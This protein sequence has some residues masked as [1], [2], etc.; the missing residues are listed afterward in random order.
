MSVRI[1]KINSSARYADASTRRLTEAVVADLL[2]R[3]PD[4]EVIDRD[5]AQG[6]PFVS[7]GHIEAVYTPT[8][9]RTPAQRQLLS[10]S[11]HLISELK[12][13]DYLVIGAPMY[14]FSV[15]ASLKAY[16]DQIAQAGVTFSYSEAGPKGLVDNIREAFVAVS[17]N[18][19]PL[20][21]PVDFLTGFVRHYLGFLGIHNVRV[22]DA[23]G[24]I[25]GPHREREALEALVAA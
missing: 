21:S 17:S 19:V 12:S 3:H 16:F 5:V 23:T 14:N 2:L 8:G 6:V 13:A 7:E 25:A 11:Q 10:S 9:E 22:L 15:P 1:L 24:Q 4:A 18:G 20:D